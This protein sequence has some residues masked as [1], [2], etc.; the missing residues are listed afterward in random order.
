MI[1]TVYVIAGPTA[2]GK[3]D[4]SISLANKVN[5]AVINSDSM[6]VYKNL[7]ILTAR[8]SINEMKSID[9]HLY[10]FVDGN[11]RYNVERWCNDAAAVIKK[12]S[13]N[14]LTPILV[15]G[16]GLYINT[17]IN[18]LIDLPS[19][20]ELIKIESEKILQEFGKDFLINQIKNIDPESLKEINYNDT[21]R[22]R[23]IWEVFESTGKKF[24]EWKLNKNKKFITNYNIKILLFLPDREK[25]YQVVNSRFINMMKEGAVEEV[26]KLLELNL[27]NSLPIMRAHGVP[28]IMKYLAN[29]INL[30]E[31]INKGQQVTRNYVKRQHT[32]W[33]SSKLQIFQ[34]FDAFPSEIDINSIKID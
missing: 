23:R 9:H 1:N 26:K 11:E 20:P 24:S 13:A 18:G 31:C 3:S 14:N 30:E 27:H 32:W 17:L 21:V 25:N 6:Q 29:E 12:T 34:Q 16:T 22:L 28:E 10:G 2:T 5:G 15:G 7:E 19:I 8:P 4:L 33:N